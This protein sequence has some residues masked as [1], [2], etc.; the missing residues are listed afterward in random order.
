MGT[1]HEHREHTVTAGNR[2]RREIMRKTIGRDRPDGAYLEIEAKVPGGESDADTYFA[3]V[4]SLWEQ[5]GTWNGR[6]RARDGRDADAAGQLR[7]KLA[8]AAPEL[9][10]LLRVHL[11]GSDGAPPHAVA[12]G[13]YFYRDAHVTYELAHY[14]QE[15][16]DRHGT[17]RERAARCLRIEPGDLPTGMDEAA[18]REFAASLAPRWAEQAAAARAAFDRLVNGDGVEVRR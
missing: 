13:W 10:P 17:G 12:N 2:E 3:V 15:Y 11:A 7:E 5:R 8:A 18:F 14:G 9:A 6:A 4:G 16:V 1:E